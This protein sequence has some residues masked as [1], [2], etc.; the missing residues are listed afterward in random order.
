MSDAPHPIILYDRVCGLCDR[1]IQFVLKRDERDLFRFASLQS[2]L[3]ARVLRGYTINPQQLDTVYVVVNFQEPDQKLLSRSE[4][5]IFVLQ[6]L[7]GTWPA[8]ARVL[9]IL[10]RRMRDAAYNLVARNRYRWFG[11]YDTCVLPDARQRH[12][13]LD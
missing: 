13:F 9:R 7:R 5:A 10:P 2:E 8:A 4:A 6:Q 1:F 3:A 12:K 11:K